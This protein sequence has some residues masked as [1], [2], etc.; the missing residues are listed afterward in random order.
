MDRM[1][2]PFGKALARDKD[3][4]VLKTARLLM[5]KY[6]QEGL[7]AHIALEKNLPLASGLGGGSADAAAAL[8]A[9]NRFW[10]LD[11]P[12]EELLDIAAEI[13][14]DVPA[15][16]LS[17]PCW[18]EGR[19]THVTKLAS[20]PPFELVLV[21]PGVAVPTAVHAAPVSGLVVLVFVFQVAS[22]V[23]ER[24][25]GHGEAVLPVM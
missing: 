15:C 20:I 3:N 5:T 18:M 24:H 2:G 17:S 6:P 1:T 16:L 13:G 23:P 7:G 4:L 12:E 25:F 9:L 8:R 19:G 22:Q 14:S 11:L 21:N 10:R